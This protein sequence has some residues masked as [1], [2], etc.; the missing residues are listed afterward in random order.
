MTRQDLKSVLTFFG[1]FM[2]IGGIFLMI[3]APSVDVIFGIGLL[4]FLTSL[5]MAIFAITWK[6]AGDADRFVGQHFGGGS[7]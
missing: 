6:I 3:I 5:I 2:F 7:N 1:F 4:L